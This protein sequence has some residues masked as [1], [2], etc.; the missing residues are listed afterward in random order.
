[1]LGGV[2]SLAA[3]VQAETQSNGSGRN[4]RTEKFFLKLILF[5]I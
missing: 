1:M 2:L 5:F 4:F 3:V